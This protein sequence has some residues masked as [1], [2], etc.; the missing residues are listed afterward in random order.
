MVLLHS[1]IRFVIMPGNAHQQFLSRTYL[2][3]VQTIVQQIIRHENAVCDSCR[4][5]IGNEQFAVGKVMCTQQGQDFRQL[6]RIRLI[7]SQQISLMEILYVICHL[8]HAILRHH[9]QICTVIHFQGTVRTA[10]ES[11]VLRMVCHTLPCLGPISVQKTV[12]TWMCIGSRLRN[13]GAERGE[14][15]GNEHR[16][17]RFYLK[18][19]RFAPL[20]LRPVNRNVAVTPVPRPG[21]KL[22]VGVEHAPLIHF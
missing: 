22:P 17:L 18:G 4:T 6:C 5:E 15:G 20:S 21:F 1:T 2:A 9:S 7:L 16:S 10:D 3:S 12:K 13:V 8:L 11:S 19:N 14:V